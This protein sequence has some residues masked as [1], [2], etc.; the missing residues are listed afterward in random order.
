MAT[1]ARYWRIVNLRAYGG[2]N[3]AVTNIQLWSGSANL[4]GTVSQ[5]V[6]GSYPVNAGLQFKWTFATAVEVSIVRVTMLVYATGLAA[7]TLQSSTDDIAWTTE[8]IYDEFIYPGDGLITALVNVTITPTSWDS[9]NK[10][11]ACTLS[12]ANLTASANY[13]ASVKSVFGATSGKYY[14]EVSC[15]GS[16]LVGIGNASARVTGAP[17][18]PGWDGNGKAL[19]FYNGNKYTNDAGAAYAP[20]PTANSVIGIKLD[21]DLGTLGFI[22]NGTDYG[23]AFSGIT[24]VMYAMFGGGSSGGA[25]TATANFGGSAFTYS[26]PTG[27]ASGF[28]V[29]AGANI[30]S[31]AIEFQQQ[32]QTVYAEYQPTASVAFATQ[33]P[34]T[35]Y[36]AENGGRGRLVGTVK[37]AGTPN[38]AV[39]R[40]VR[41]HRDRDGLL[42]R[43]QWSD[44]VTGIYS[45]TD[46]DMTK[47]YTIIAY[48]HTFAYRAVL[49]DNVTPE[50]M[51]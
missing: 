40:R 50:L 26:V 13:S 39:Q 35:F 20:T 2:G 28:G 5:A 10:G 7:C 44:P 6:N 8:A 36:D 27:Y 30:Q 38:T 46:I 33:M 4:G 48:D 47:T 25:D 32:S 21:M 34:V 51:T 15:T 24:G 19:Y 22:V 14:F 11:S 17:S 49:A 23:E 16:G 3:V 45:F 31:R 41:L 12:N 37:V 18:Y 42:I 43:E 1:S 29:G 9:A